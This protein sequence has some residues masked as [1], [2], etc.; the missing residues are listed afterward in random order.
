MKKSAVLLVIVVMLITPLVPAAAQ[1]N[2]LDPCTA[3]EITL[4]LE[5]LQPVTEA[6]DAAAES[7]PEEKL[8]WL[9]LPVEDFVALSL[10]YASIDDSLAI[11][12]ETLP[13][14]VDSTLLASEYDILVSSLSLWAMQMALFHTYEVD[15]DSDAPSFKDNA[16]FHMERVDRI[17]ETIAAHTEALANGEFLPEWAACT[18]AELTGEYVTFLRLM[19]GNVPLVVG[20]ISLITGPSSSQLLRLDTLNMMFLPDQHQNTVPACYELQMLTIETYGELADLSIFGMVT[21]LMT[22]MDKAGNT[23]AEAALQAIFEARWTATI[24]A[25]TKWSTPISPE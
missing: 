3:G 6:L 20:E 14:C 23:E 22:H 11:T 21:K 15:G 19:E 16:I 10:T 7:W 8:D 25:Y 1:E 2:H 12:V 13:A 9:E 4:L 17:T 18:D 5:T 24:Q